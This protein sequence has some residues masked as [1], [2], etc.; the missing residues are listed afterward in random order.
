MK[1]FIKPFLLVFLLLPSFS[2][3]GQVASNHSLSLTLLGFEYSYE[4]RLA[5]RWSLT[6]RGGLIT[7]GTLLAMYPGHFENNWT[8]APGITIEPRFYTSMGRRLQMGR[9]IHNNSSDFVSMRITGYFAGFEDFR[10]SVTPLYGIR[11]SETKHWFHEFA[12]GPQFTI[13][14]G[15]V[16]TITYRLGYLF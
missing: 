12:F 13:G 15:I 2:C 9:D 16:P 3:H 11:R 5:D 4:Q 10:M 8:M 6:G 7:Y 1:A 14:E